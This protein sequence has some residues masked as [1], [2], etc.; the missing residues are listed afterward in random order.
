MKM[1]YDEFK[2]KMMDFCEVRRIAWDERD[3]EMDEEVERAMLK[4][5]GENPEFADKWF[6][7]L[8]AAMQR[9]EWD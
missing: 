5:E 4:L 7:D 2:K 8:T 3:M 6:K 1:T 9:D